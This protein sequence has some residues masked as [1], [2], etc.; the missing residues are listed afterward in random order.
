MI[1]CGV[2]AVCGAAWLGGCASGG[3]TEL[4]IGPGEYAVAFDAARDVL[5]DARFEI[6]RVDARAGVI[7]TAPKTTT[8]R[9]LEDVLNR[10]G[11]RVRVSFEPAG[12][13]VGGEAGEAAE[14][15]T[16]RDLLTEEPGELVMRVRGVV[17][18]EQRPGWR[19]ESSAAHLSTRAEDPA[20]VR[21]GME[22]G[23]TV[24]VREDAALG[25][26]LAQRIAK[27]LRRSAGGD[28]ASAE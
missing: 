14:G 23:Y 9:D 1:V 18:R 7:T 6:D 8:W 19:L 21:R 20:L 2:W 22:P 25:G 13:P 4:A 15:N 11:R 24:A 26:E 12:E 27:R 17:E 28:D 10:H 3:A 16:I 5:R